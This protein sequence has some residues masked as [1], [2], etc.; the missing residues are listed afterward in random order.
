MLCTGVVDRMADYEKLL[1]PGFAMP[2]VVKLVRYIR[3]PYA[4]PA[5]TRPNILHRDDYTCQYCG[6]RGPASEMTIDHVQ[7]RSRGGTNDWLN[8]VTACSPC[9]DRKK[10]KTPA[11]AN[12]PLRRKPFRPNNRLA[13]EIS[14][15]K[16]LEDWLKRYHQGTL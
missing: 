9:N 15:H 8:V 10:S 11:E 16:H 7:P 6:K 1:R 3:V 2:K 14:K 13:F 12:M 4:A 5:V